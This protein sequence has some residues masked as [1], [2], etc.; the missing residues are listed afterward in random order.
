MNNVYGIFRQYNQKQ[1][2][3]RTKNSSNIEDR[4]FRENSQQLKAILAKS[5]ILVTSLASEHASDL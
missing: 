5:S 1:F 4:A 3:G 2:Q